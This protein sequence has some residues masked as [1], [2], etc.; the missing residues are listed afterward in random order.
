MCLSLS[1]S[2]PSAIPLNLIISFS[3]SLDYFLLPVSHI[4]LLHLPIVNVIFYLFSVRLQLLSSPLSIYPHMFYSIL[5]LLILN[6]ECASRGVLA[7]KPS[8]L[9]NQ[10]IRPTQALTVIPPQLKHSIMSLFHLR[11]QAHN[12]WTPL[13]R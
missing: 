9:W 10:G 1:L 6:D 3:L 5:Y 8:L 12:G 11:T 4:N 13:I 7:V 2:R